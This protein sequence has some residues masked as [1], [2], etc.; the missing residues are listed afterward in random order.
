MKRRLHIISLRV[1]I[2]VVSIPLASASAATWRL[3]ALRAR[4]KTKLCNLE[5]TSDGQH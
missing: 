1:A 4:L 2:V 5:A 3:E